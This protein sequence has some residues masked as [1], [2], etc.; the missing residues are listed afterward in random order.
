MSILMIRPIATKVAK[1]LRSFSLYLMLCLFIQTLMAVE[2]S[3]CQLHL[4]QQNNTAARKVFKPNGVAY[5]AR[6]IWLS[7]FDAMGANNP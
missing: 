1:I 7:V 2:T 6:R 3:P 4:F 5:T